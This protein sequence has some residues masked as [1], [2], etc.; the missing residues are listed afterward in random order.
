MQEL[1]ISISISLSGQPADLVIE[2]F[3]AG[4]GEAVMFP[5]GQETFDTFAYGL[6]HLLE[7]VDR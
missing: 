5:K 7:A 4:T 2:D 6:G 1:F 3:L